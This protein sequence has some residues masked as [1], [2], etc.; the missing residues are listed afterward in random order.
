M[1]ESDKTSLSLLERA[2]SQQP[3]AWER[4]VELYAPLVRHWCRQADLQ[5]EDLA[6]VFQTVFQAIAQH[7]P[8]FRH[9]RP[10]DSFRGWLRVVTRNKILDH[11]RQRANEPAAMGGSAAKEMIDA[12]SDP[13]IEE[14]DDTEV[15]LVQSQ[16][17]RALQ[18]IESEVGEQTWK[19]FW[20]IQM[21]NQTPKEVA[22]RLGMTAAAVRKARY[23]VLTRLREELEGLDC[24][25]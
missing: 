11:F 12:M 19:A 24:Q 4:L 9:D 18:W 22:E 7:L 14:E 17:T 16:I 13:L 23:R 21:D 2:C 20:A 6:D 5:G 25:L 3:D 15:R 1:S 8:R 10:S